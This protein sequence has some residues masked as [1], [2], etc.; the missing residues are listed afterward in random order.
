MDFALGNLTQH[1]F[2]DTNAAE[3]KRTFEAY[4]KDYNN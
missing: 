2:L 4:A 3:V 1:N